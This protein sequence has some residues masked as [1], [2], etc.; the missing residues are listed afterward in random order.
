MR[1]AIPTTNGRLHPHFG[2]CSA[3]LL[4]DVAPDR[5]IVAESEI[6]APEHQPGLL[7]LWLKEHGVQLVIAGNM[8]SR[9]RALFEENAIEV[10]TGAPADTPMQIIQQYLNGTLP[11]MENTCH[12]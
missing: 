7:P 12:H 2:H 9:A 11:T 10:R 1:I 3:F 4:M 5:T 8:G 6:A